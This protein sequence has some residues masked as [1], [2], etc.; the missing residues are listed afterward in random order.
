M[1]GS[2]TPLS[3]S[4]SSSSSTTSS[5]NINSQRLSIERTQNNNIKISQHKNQRKRSPRFFFWTLNFGITNKN[6][7]ISPNGST[8]PST[9]N[10]SR[11]VNF[12]AAESW[13]WID[14]DYSV[15]IEKLG[16]K[17]LNN[18]FTITVIYKIS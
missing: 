3:I 1:G 9:P 13:P 6:K 10:S 5:T 15:V 18:E 8:L 11:S 2:T 16:E 17:Y 14:D 7:N 12:E 4:S